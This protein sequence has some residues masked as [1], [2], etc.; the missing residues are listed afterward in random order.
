ME[1]PISV[2]HLRWAMDLSVGTQKQSDSLLLTNPSDNLHVI[3]TSLSALYQAATCHQ[4]CHGGNHILESLAGRT[5]NLGFA[6]FALI[7][8]GFYDEALNL[9]RSIGEISNLILLSVIDKSA[10]KAWLESDA[11]T[12]KRNFPPAKIRKILEQHDAPF[13]ATEDWYSTLYEKYTHV[14]PGTKPNMH[15]DS[16]RPVVGGIFQ[17]EGAET[18]LSELANALGSVALVICKYFKFADLFDVIVP[19]SKVA[20]KSAATSPDTH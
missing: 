10:L 18:S 19:H 11:K 13:L 12:R 4:K 9:T 17:E 1:I 3:G 16:K 7:R 8:Q 2:E 20:L 6:S 14:H 5:Y 15:N